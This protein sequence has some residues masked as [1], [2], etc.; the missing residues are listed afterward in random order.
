MILQYLFHGY[1]ARD[2]EVKRQMQD[3]AINEMQHLGWLAE[4][5]VGNQGTPV[6]EHTEVDQ[7][8]TANN[9][10]RADVAIENE[11]AR[12]YREAADNLVEPG[13]KKLLRRIADQEEY[14]AAAFQDLLDTE[15]VSGGDA[16]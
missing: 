3:Q 12:R 1:M 8:V 2:P 13:L 14:H 11:V 5:L 6:M 4:E 7:S 15:T 9:M 10:L 16:A